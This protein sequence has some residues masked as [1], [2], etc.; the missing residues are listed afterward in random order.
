MKSYSNPYKIPL[1]VQIPLNSIRI[2]K[3][4]SLLNLETVELT[5]RERVLLV[6]A[7]VG[8]LGVFQHIYFRQFHHTF[9][10]WKCRRPWKSA[11][12]STLWRSHGFRT[13]I[14][15]AST[16]SQ[17]LCNNPETPPRHPE[18]ARATPCTRSIYIY[19]EL[20]RRFFRLITLGIYLSS[21]KVGK[22]YF[23]VTDK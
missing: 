6:A 10:R 12:R 22:Q 20:A 18:I 3:L 1:N 9:H 7:M 23:R 19:I 15:I 17:S 2:L 11:S 4:R 13:E 8:F 21:K 14:D 16:S 5:D